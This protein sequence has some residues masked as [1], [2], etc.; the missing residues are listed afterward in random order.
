M[1]IQQYVNDR[2]CKVAYMSQYAD[3][4]LQTS[5]LVWGHSR[6]PFIGRWIMWWTAN[7]RE[8]GG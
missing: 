5:S 2:K 3:S 4:I 7:V 8:L 1:E 6:N